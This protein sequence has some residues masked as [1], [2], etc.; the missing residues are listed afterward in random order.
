MDELRLAVR[1]LTKRPGASFV[2]I[3]TLACAIGA[4]AATW[5]LL[6]AVLLRPLPVK[7]ADRLVVPGTVMKLGQVTAPYYGF[8]YPLLPV[9]RNAGI[10]EGVAA[11][12]SSPLSLLTATT[13]GSLPVRTNVGFATYDLFDLLGL[14]VPLG[15]KFT[16][17]DDRRGAPPA[18]ILTDRY[19]RSAFD[20]RTDVLGRTIT[21]AGKPAT[22]VGVA[23][24]G[25]RGLDL[26]QSVDLYL[27][28]M[29]IADVGS[30]ITNYFAEEGHP[31]SPTSGVK[32]VGKLG[33]ETSAA[34]AGSRLAGLDLPGYR[35]GSPRP[36]YVVTPINLAAIPS[37]ARAGMMEFTRLLGTTV[38]LL[39]LIGCGTVGMLLL[40]RTEARREELA[41]CVALGASRG[42]LARGIAFEGALLSAAGAIAAVPVAWWLFSGMSASQLPGRIDIGLLDL[43]LDARV[44]AS[45]AA[46]ALLASMVISLI[47][48][49][50]GITAN[51]AESLRT[52]GGATPL[53]TRRRTRAALVTAQVAVAMVLAAGAGLFARSLSAALSLNAGVAMDRIVSGSIYL[54]PYGYNVPRATAFFDDLSAALRANP[55]LDS[56]AYS[57][58]QGGMGG[59]LSVDNVPRQF[60]SDVWFTS[61]DDSY[62]RTMGLN[63]I[64]GRNFADG[65]RPGS[66]LVAIVSESF[67]RKLAD[68]GSPI[69]R[70]VKMPSSRNGRPPDVMEVVGVVGD[71]VT[72][73]S[74]LEPL[75]MYFPL[76]QADPAMG[77]TV[78]VRAAGTSDAA[79]REIIGAIKA[80][81]PAVAPS[82]LIT[83]EERIGQQ[84]AP[85]RLGAIVLGALGM[86][87]VL[88]TI[89]GTYVVSESMAAMRMREM[90]IRAAL[91]A[92]RGQLGAI[93]MAET[94]RLVGVG[95]IVGLGLAWLGANTIRAFLFQVKPFDPLT[96][97][98]V[99]GTILTL[100]L[101]VSVRPALRAARVDLGTVLKDQ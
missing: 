24:P 101:I 35:A 36:A 9:V 64:A 98:A 11:E 43:T 80:V 97:A 68:G 1:R 100:A 99:A 47:A 90:G 63:V 67:A 78:V 89:L 74:V 3:V 18:A 27:P 17:N 8:N 37:R 55:A 21:I 79:R 53:A 22:I 65:D 44:V 41:L 58:F 13:E 15:R 28:F 6:S 45:A 54:D 40:I 91:G 16:Q 61:V 56:V 82:P 60:P 29:T 75:D 42:R 46:F 94:G 38:A 87:A 33:T 19:W 23:Q 84:M 25:F 48:A 93:V 71:V 88:L 66:P 85:Q 51:A 83:L 59:K 86:I 31:S 14:Q 62:F 73:I 95:L 70:R 77:R 32:L 4:A 30:P 69:G 34:Q 72:R 10:F 52:R 7:D 20:A 81:D 92:T 5:S 2:S 50:F 49:T 57:V 76:R 96:L 39:L 26:S 12:W